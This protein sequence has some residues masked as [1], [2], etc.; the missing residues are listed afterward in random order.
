MRLK[1]QKPKYQVNTPAGRIAGL[2]NCTLHLRYNVQPWVGALTWDLWPRTA[3]VAG[4]KESVLTPF[5]RAIEGGRSKVFAMPALKGAAGAGAAGTGT[6]KEDLGTET[7]G[8]ANRGSP[9]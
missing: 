3:V 7:G 6:K 1:D 2:E 5:W 4:K 9:A 8:E